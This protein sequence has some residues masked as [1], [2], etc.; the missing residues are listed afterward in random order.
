MKW[1]V[2]ISVCFAAS[3]IF[4][5]YPIYVIRPFRQQGPGELRL[6]LEVL[7][8]RPI[9]MVVAAVL[10]AVEA[11]RYWWWEGTSPYPRHGAAR[12]P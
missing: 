10:A 8:L 11:S 1:T 3:L 12:W 5:A 7:R 4:L 9:V 2:L 6:A